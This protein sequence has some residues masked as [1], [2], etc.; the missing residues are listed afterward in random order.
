[1]N[2]KLDFTNIKSINGEIL[3]SGSK[4]ESNRLLILQKLYSG[5]NINNLSNSE[6]TEVLIKALK[7]KEKIINIGHAGTA[8]R[9]LTAYYCIVAETTK[10][11]TGSS[12][13]QER[14][15]QILVDALKQ[16]GVHISYLK[17]EGFPPIIIKGKKIR[18]NKVRIKANVSSQYITALLLIAPALSNGLE[19]VLEGEITSKPY[20][21]MTLSLLKKI[22]V[23]YTFDNNI[24][25]IKSLKIAD[26]K[27]ISIDIEA[28]WSSASYYY[29]L[30]ALHS[31][32]K[33]ELKGFK[34]DSI[35]GDSIL[36]KLYQNLGVQTK[37]TQSGIV[38]SSNNKSISKSIIKIDMSEFPDLAQTYAVTCFGLGINC[39]LTGLHTLKIKETDRLLALKNELEKLGAKLVITES[40]LQLKATKIINKD[41]LINTY[42]DHRMAMAF[43][44]LSVLTPI[45]IE[46]PDVI[47][48]SYPN[49]WKDW[50]RLFQ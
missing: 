5:I 4:S 9:F 34:K 13:M 14:P 11:L 38:I 27:A 32:V 47:G 31:Q 7:S 45:F 30:A 39:H 37:Y 20:I 41:I 49:F 1:M 10:T 36:P 25:L 24:I 26:Y 18:K 17:Q 44:P 29:S 12:R 48:K 15:I 2:L 43:T 28:D 21:K 19:L 8:M 3:I 42:H 40:S 50:K 6:D 46:N 23:E 35:Q 16:L 33:I 22:G